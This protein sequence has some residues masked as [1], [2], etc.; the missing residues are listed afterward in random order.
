MPTTIDFYCYDCKT[1][2]THF[3]SEGNYTIPSKCKAQVKKD[4]KAKNF[5][6]KK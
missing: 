2:F 5:L 6:Q 1:C 3:L 4:C